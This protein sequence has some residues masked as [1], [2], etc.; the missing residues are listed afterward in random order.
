MTAV[1]VTAH[2]V[3]AWVLRQ[4]ADRQGRAGNPGNPGGPGPGPGPGPAAPARL[5][6]AEVDLGPIADT[7]VLVEPIYGCWEGNMF[8]ALN[9][10][11]VDVCRQR[12][13]PWV[14]I[15]NAGVVRVL[16][17]GRSVP[18]RPEGS[19]CLVFPNAD[20][21]PHGYMRRAYAYDATATI[22]LLARTTKIPACALLPVP[23]GTRF[24]LRQWA[25]FSAR[26]IT[27][28]SNWQ[29]AHAC[30]RSQMTEADQARPHVWAWG[31]GVALA[32]TTLAARL[33]AD[34][35]MISSRDAR[36]AQ[37][38]ALGVVP[39]DRREFA[40][41]AYD[42]ARYRTDPAYR[43]AYRAA[44]DRFLDIVDANTGGRRVSIFVDNIGLPVHR[45]TLRALA[46]QGVLATCGWRHGMHLS[47]VR[48]VECIERH[49][50]VHTHYAR[51]AEGLAAIRYAEETGWIPPD[52]TRVWSW[53]EVPALA[54][55]YR[56]G[57]VD[58]YF[59]LYQINPDPNDPSEP[60]NRVQPAE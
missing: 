36:L 29:V 8:H 14:V 21:D 28:W 35:A 56:A 26:Y 50:H 51:A 9:R 16:R 32:E 31:G 58:D 18:D 7:E 1:T 22:G 37:I 10:D 43:A 23:A 11:P 19:H 54:E 2:T 6:L 39:I 57:Q 60:P 45:A 13:E 59:A 52:T 47:T 30:W 41:L 17:A 12:G 27:A 24:T 33:G 15:G 55:Q 34:A 25:A 46:R 38:A 44:E 48:A 5:E 20:P 53:H 3:E 42:P 4:G 40:E 49:I